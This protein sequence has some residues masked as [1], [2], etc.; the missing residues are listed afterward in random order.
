MGNGKTDFALLLAELW[1]QNKNGKIGSNI[2]S[3]KQKDRSI[4]S[5]PQLKKWINKNQENITN[6]LFV[7]D[8]ASQYATGQGKKGYLTQKYF[9]KLLREFRKKQTTLI[10]IGHTGKD[11][12]PDIRSNVDDIIEKTSK[13]KAKIW[14]TLKNGEPKELQTT[15]KN[16]PKT[17]FKYNTKEITKW[18]WKKQQNQEKNQQSKPKKEIK[19]A[20]K[21]KKNH[22]LTNQ[23]IADIINKSKRTVTRYL[24][25]NQNQN[26][27]NKQK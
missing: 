4:K 5:F 6:K 21:L 1:K 24:N 15:L 19:I 18:K 25:K 8:E 26:Q 14:N 11:I 27:K 16:I 17:T 13:K 20:N 23:E 7:F 2:E 12:H 10:I 9:G 3:F 22:N